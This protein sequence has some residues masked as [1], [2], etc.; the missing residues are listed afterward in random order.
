[1]RY[2]FLSLLG[3]C[4]IGCQ[5]VV[6]TTGVVAKYQIAVPQVTKKTVS[7][8]FTLSYDSLFSYF[9]FQPGKVL[10]DSKNQLGVDFPLSMR[11]LQK[12]QVLVRQNGLLG[13]VLPVQVDARPSIA[14]INAGLIQ[15]K[16][17]LFLD[18]NWNWKD[19]N[20][21][22]ISDIKFDYSWIS[23]PEMRV[24]GFPVKVQGVVEPLINRQIPD[25]QDKLGRQLNQV[26]SLTSLTGI[27]NRI[28]MSFDTQVGT[29]RLHAAEIDMKDLVFQTSGLQGKLQVRTALDIADTIKYQYNSRWTELRS[30][31]NH[32]PFRIELSYKRLE[33][34]FRNSP[35]F[36]TYQFKLS[37][38]TTSIFVKLNAINGQKAEARIRLNPVLIDSNTIGLQVKS[39]NLVGVPFFIRRHLQRKIDYSISQ[40]RYSGAESLKLLKQNTWGLRLV[41]G[42]VNI[43]TLLFTDTGIGL[44]GEI[45]GNWELRK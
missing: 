5:R 20:H 30:A 8:D 22:N 19:I 13:I 2:I 41:D 32:L 7:I 15:A 31:S 34:F 28:P 18:L 3:I 45:I 10:F 27:L 6:P 26:T 39:I 24:L 17:N 23:Q 1:M 43:S 44:L 42:Q 29:I 14:G 9:K 4:L 33:D 11:V 25:I 21:R 38:D 37:A 40:F 36:K 16:S 35:Q 12:P